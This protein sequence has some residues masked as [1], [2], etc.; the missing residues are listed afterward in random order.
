MEIEIKRESKNIKD[1]EEMVEI[2]EEE[3]K[4]DYKILAY[5]LPITDCLDSVS[6]FILDS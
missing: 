4:W 5:S 6:Y 1:R 3:V 2:G